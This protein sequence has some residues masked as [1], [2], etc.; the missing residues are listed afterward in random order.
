MLTE[1]VV[2]K[3]QLS[4]EAV[5]AGQA[6][7]DWLI[8]SLVEGKRLMVIHPSEQCRKQSIERLHALGAG[9]SID[10]SHHVTINRLIS[11]LHVDLRLPVL[12]SDDG[13]L[14][15]KTHR[16]L[17]AEASGESFSGLLSNP[18]HKWSRSRTRRLLSLYK[19]LTKLKRPWDWEEDPSKNL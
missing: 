16:A 4:M 14:F 3:T 5:P 9:K 10:P 7:P 1:A 13:I 2:A 18:K 6:M 8:S 11:I 19:E 12:L 15:E 17:S